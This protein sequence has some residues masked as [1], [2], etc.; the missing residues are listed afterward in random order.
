MRILCFFVGMISYVHEHLTVMGEN[1]KN[2]SHPPFITLRSWPREVLETLVSK[3][4]SPDQ[5]HKFHLQLL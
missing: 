5:Q 3:V 4:G 2:V 1:S